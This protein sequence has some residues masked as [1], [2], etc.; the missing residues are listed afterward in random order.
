[1]LPINNQSPL[2]PARASLW[3]LAR[4]GQV[5]S[6]TSVQPTHS[7]LISSSSFAF[8]SSSIISHPSLATFVPV[9]LPPSLCC[10]FPHNYP[11]PPHPCLP[12]WPLCPS[13]PPARASLLVHSRL[14]LPAAHSDTRSRP[15][16][17]FSSTLLTS[18]AS[19][20]HIIREGNTLHRPTSSFIALGLVFAAQSQ[21]SAVI[22]YLPRSYSSVSDSLIYFN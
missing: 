20:I 15:R 9:P 11:I 5:P 4:S 17:Q 8:P 19:L 7:I 22:S 12:F 13:S 18:P 10:T 21:A 1:M 2:L 3:T 14:S 16:P 6:V